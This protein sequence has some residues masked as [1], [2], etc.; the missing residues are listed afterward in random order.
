[1][2]RR[3]LLLLFSLHASQLHD[4]LRA[5]RRSWSS[6]SLGLREDWGESG[7]TPRGK[8]G[9]IRV[10]MGNSAFQPWLGHDAAT[11]V[12]SIGCVETKGLKLAPRERHY[13]K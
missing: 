1:V 8:D 6:S 5:R 9:E 12:F 10:R 4:G 13:K 11:G 2:D 3:F 7:G